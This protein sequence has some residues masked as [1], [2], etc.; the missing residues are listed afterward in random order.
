MMSTTD[1]SNPLLGESLTRRER[2]IMALLAD[3]LTGAEIAER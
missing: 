3:G 1:P 2:E